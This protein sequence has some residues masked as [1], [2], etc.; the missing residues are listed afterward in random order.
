MRIALCG[1]P[2]VG[3]STLF[4]RLTGMHQHTGNWIG[5]TVTNSKGLYLN[6]KSIEIFDLPGT[7]SLS[8][9]S[10]EEEVARDFICFGGVDVCIVV[11]DALCLE[12]NLNLV[13]QV[14]EINSN[15][16]LCINMM[17][18]A[19]KK[20][21]N[22]DLD[23]LSNILGIPVY[24]VVARKGEGI[25]SVMN[26]IE[27]KG[28]LLFINY[29]DIVEEAIDI[30]YPLVSDINI[31]SRWLALK[32][33][34]DDKSFLLSLSKY[35]PDLF[36]DKILH[37]KVLEARRF[38]FD[39][40]ID[41]DDLSD[42][43]VSCINKRCSEISDTVVKYSKDCFSK[44]RIIDKFLT[45]RITG[46]PIM[47]LGLL[48][49]FWLT[50]VFSNYPSDL[51]FDFFCWFEKYL[52]SFLS[53]FGLPNFLVSLFVDGIYRVLTWVISVMLP[54]MVIFFS[55]FTLL[56]DIGYLPR[57]AFT[58]DNSFRKCSACGKQSL[59]MAMGFGCNAVGITGSRI[60]DSPRERLISILTNSFVPCNGRFPTIIMLISM[61]FV[62]NGSSFLSALFLTI[63]IV[64]SVFMTFLVSFILSKTLLKGEVSS[65][66][67]E[68]PT[69]RKPVIFKTIVRSVFDRTLKILYK[70][71]KV[72]SVAGVVIWFLSNV[73]VNDI[74]LL[75]TFSMFL[76]RFGALMGLDGAIL[77]GFIFGFPANEIVFPI[78]LM[79]YMSSGNLVSLPNLDVLRILLIEHNWTIVTAVC[80][81]L[82]CLFH[83]PCSTSCLTIYDETKSFKWTLI[84]FFLPTVIGAFLC[85]IVNFI[86]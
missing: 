20:N 25:D 50:I 43:I 21:I 3:K 84:S 77:C 54:P 82:F 73:S 12:R 8:S 76:D 28:N 58:L 86:V 46:I 4:N 33:I 47:I 7:Y 41:L 72:S 36:I 66:I 39:N 45:N 34:S 30:V 26:S 5:K 31:N 37:E 61:F 69:F 17:D 64:L 40:G 68:L 9:S 65:F 44:N 79:I 57:V 48:L 16:I 15:V 23:M 2:N 22:I 67:L 81:I 29:G 27:F 70:A 18:D 13:L 56:E 85:M 51:L 80:M 14:M 11:C 38:L 32:L 63:V 10:K 59:T 60:I 53:F 42:I 55:I 6:D 49:I 52:F 74:S 78:I 62:G 35:F 24:G 19:L 75:N 1:N 83:F 71:I